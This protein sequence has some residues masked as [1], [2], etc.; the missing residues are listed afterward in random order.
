[1]FI[2]NDKGYFLM[3]DL[4]IIADWKRGGFHPVYWLEGEEPY[5]IDKITAFAEQHILDAS[6]AGFNLS[7]FYGKDSKVEEVIN[8][9]RRYPMLS[10]RQ[11]VILKEAQ[12]LRDIEKL[13]SYIENPLSSTIF[14]VAHKDK[15][16]DGRGKLAKVIK[17]KAVLYAAKK[18]YDNELPDWAV[19]MIKGKGLDITSK[20]LHIF[21]DHIGNDLQRMENEITKMTLNLNGRI[22][23][24]EDDIEE[25]VGVSKEFNVFELQSS[26]AR[27]D[28]TTALRILNYFAANPKAAPI[29][30]VLPTLYSFFSKLYIAA[31][32][33]TRD[34]NT[35]GNAL[36][37]KGFLARQYVQAIQV[38]GFTDVEK[39]LILL[40]DCN[41]KSLGIKRAVT[42]DNILMKE[43]I[44]KIM[45][46]H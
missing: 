14:I 3:D 2:A 11:V 37:I 18:L 35:I 45:M 8:A 25:F 15:K 38:Y 31:A 16:L 29:Q 39:V 43:L 4:Q 1:M 34:E 41:L 7:V 28:I 21:V 33:G 40:S 24:S 46:S 44:V 17:Q 10:D 30:L 20:A 26:I 42:D 32:L 13:E 5:Y 19:G 22:K 36:G 23:V 9:C 27:K 12:Q 6:A